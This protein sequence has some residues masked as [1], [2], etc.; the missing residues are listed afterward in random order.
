MSAV[1]IFML[2]MLT[3][4]DRFFGEKAR[5]AMG[6]KIVTVQPCIFLPAFSGQEARGV[7]LMKILD[8]KH[9]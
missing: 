1:F 4:F 2:E 5:L 8:K 9:L 7:R 3:C 6:N